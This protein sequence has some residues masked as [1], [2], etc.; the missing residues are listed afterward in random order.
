[1]NFPTDLQYSK[2]HT[3]L[4]INGNT[5]TI[6]ITEFAQ[7]ELGEIVYPDFPNT[8]DSFEKGKVF[9]SVEA[10]KTV[11]DLYM[12]V[13]GKIVEINKKLLQEPTLINE[14]P[15]GE[16]WLIKIDLT[17]STES[18]DLLDAAAYQTLTGN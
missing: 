3:W 1:M 5:G 9:G 16:G 6:G 12:P 2:E 13:S 11:S 18:H 17:N 10:L 7:S 8:G 15:Y 14:D 4:R